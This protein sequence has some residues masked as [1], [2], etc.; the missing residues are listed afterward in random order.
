MTSGK[1]GCVCRDTSFS[2][3]QLVLQRI[4]LFCRV[5]RAL[6]EGNDLSRRRRRCIAV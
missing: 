3:P 6:L 5:L 4:H 2:P 1:A